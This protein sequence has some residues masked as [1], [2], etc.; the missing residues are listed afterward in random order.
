LQRRA[1]SKRKIVPFIK[2]YGVDASEFELPVEAFESFDAFFTRKLKAT[3]RP[4]AA[5]EEVAIIPADA[6]YLFFQDI[7]AADGFVV[8]GAKFTLSE[9]LQDEA[10]AKTYHGG[11]MLIA[12]LCPTDYHRFHFPL[13]GVPSV[14]KLI[15]G[16]L[17]SVNPLALRTN[18]DIFTQ[19]KRMLTHLETARFGTLLCIEVGA[20]NV[21]SIIQTYTP[22]VFH[23]KGAEKG[24]FSFGAS[25]LIVLFPP[26]R[27]VFDGDLVAATAQGL[28]MRCLLGQSLGK[29]AS[30]ERV[31]ERKGERASGGHSSI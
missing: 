30:M 15:N 4:I 21:G 29:M 10:L 5:A 1:W 23:H 9:L 14:A 12:R 26:K 31:G 25:A 7:D 27:I 11:A 24:Y 17:Y 18:I 8:K 13:A 2:K 16:W 19:N 22:Q 3:A 28:E 20:T 6:R